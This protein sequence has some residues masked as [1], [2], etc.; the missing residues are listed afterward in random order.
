MNKVWLH[1]FWLG[2]GEI[3]RAAIAV[4]GVQPVIQRAWM[5][6]V[7]PPYYRGVGIGIRLRRNTLRLG[8]CYP[9]GTLTL[10]DTDAEIYEAVFGREV[11]QIQEGTWH[12][13]GDERSA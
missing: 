2:W 3:Q 8:V 13:A 9:A 1:T 10:P 5:R 12:D 7:A 11:D 6:S 4:E